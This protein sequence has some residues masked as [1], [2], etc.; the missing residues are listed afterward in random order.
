MPGEEAARSTKAGTME[1]VPVMRIFERLGMD[2][3]GALPET[4][5][6]N[7]YLLVMV[8]YLAKRA[9]A[10]PLQKDSAA[11]VAQK[12]VEEVGLHR[13]SS[14][15]GESN[16]S[17]PLCPRSTSCLARARITQLLIALGAHG[18]NDDWPEVIKRLQEAREFARKNIEWAQVKQK[19]QYDAKRR[20][21]SHR[22]VSLHPYKKEG[23]GKE[24]YL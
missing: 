24:A 22:V 12:Y 10:F 16:S 3:V 2:L 11:E 6:G 13:S 21:I 8:Y 19:V 23:E 1:P 18:D 9:E 20:D 7:R 5:R 15:T 14:P 4:A 17:V